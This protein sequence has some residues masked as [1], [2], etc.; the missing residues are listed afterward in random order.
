M[1]PDDAGARGLPKAFRDNRILTYFRHICGDTE[2]LLQGST[3]AFSQLLC[4]KLSA[5]EF[6]CKSLRAQV[7]VAW[8]ILRF[9]GSRV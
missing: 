2:L 5:F 3:V 4:L 1:T 7:P 8:V 6:R 9:I